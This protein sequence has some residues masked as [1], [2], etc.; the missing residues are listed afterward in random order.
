[1]YLFERN[2]IPFPPSSSATKS[3]SSCEKWQRNQ[4]QSFKFEMKW[5][6]VL[7]WNQYGM[8]L[9]V[10]YFLNS[11]S[12]SSCSSIQHIWIIGRHLPRPA[13][14]KPTCI[15]LTAHCNSVFEKSKSFHCVPIYPLLMLERK[16]FFL[17]SKNKYTQTSESRASASTR[18]RDNS[19]LHKKKKHI[20]FYL[21]IY[22]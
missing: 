16:F 10:V 4:Q 6:K 20:F 15:T 21:L 8:L 11:S 3:S 17:L 19:G 12:S 14:S 9:P 22:Y 1:M 13:K 5:K 2:P 18:N 7:K